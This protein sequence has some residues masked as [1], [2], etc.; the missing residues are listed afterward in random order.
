MAQ[1][2]GFHPRRCSVLDGS[3]F[4]AP[5][6]LREPARGTGQAD[7]G[8][9]LF[10]WVHLDGLRML[11][12]LSPVADLPQYMPALRGDRSG[13]HIAELQLWSFSPSF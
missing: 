7:I 2:A 6:A 12:Q 11:R 3:D 10:R 4:C 13:T 8:I 5:Y 1:G 9:D